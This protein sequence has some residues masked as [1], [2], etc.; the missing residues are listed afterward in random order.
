MSTPEIALPIRPGEHACCRFARSEDRE[1]LTVAFLRA[2]LAR[3]LKVIDLYG[4]DAQERL[5]ER[6]CAEHER[7]ESALASGQL[8]LRPAT[9]AYLPDGTF[10]P[11]G[12]CAVLR[13]E[14]RDACTAGYNGLAIT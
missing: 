1:R 9:P 5:R 12:M 7:A 11:A 6:L 4:E 8:E 13:A 2:G 14:H 3:G 10:V